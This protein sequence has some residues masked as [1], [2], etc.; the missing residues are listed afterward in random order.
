MD[1]DFTRDISYITQESNKPPHIYKHARFIRFI[2]EHIGELGHTLDIGERNT[3]TERLEMEFSVKID[4]ALGDLDEEL[5]CPGNQY[6][7]VIFSHVIEHL[8]NPL[9]CLENIKKVMKHDSILIIACPVKPHFLT[10]GRG[11][12]HEMD[13][14]RLKKLLDRAGFEIMVWEKF[15]NLRTWRSFI[16]VR[17]I[18]RLLFRS[19]TMVI[20]RKQSS[21]YSTSAR[22]KALEIEEKF[23]TK[24]S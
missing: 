23:K 17:P 4:S 22:T 20:C 1:K 18:L 2:R 8:F 15:H 9:L 19:Q 21:L 11:H 16:G 13:S 14:Y 3:L 24:Q 5:I 6:D 7:L 10:W 12:F